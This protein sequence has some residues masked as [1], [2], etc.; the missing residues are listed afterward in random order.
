[1]RLIERQTE[2]DFL[3]ILHAFVYAEIMGN[4]SEA[5]ME[6]KKKYDCFNLIQKEVLRIYF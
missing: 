1:M 5:A 2:T 6:A 3:A 4:I